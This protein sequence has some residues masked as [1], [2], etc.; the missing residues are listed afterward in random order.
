MKTLDLRKKKYEIIAYSK[1]SPNNVQVS[2]SYMYKDDA[3]RN[4]VL[5]LGEPVTITYEDALPDNVNVFAN[6]SR[7]PKGIAKALKVAFVNKTED[8]DYI[9]HDFSSYYCYSITQDK[10]MYSKSLDLFVVVD[11]TDFQTALDKVLYAQY[12][13]NDFKCVY[14]GGIYVLEGNLFDA[15]K[16]SVKDSAKFVDIKAVMKKY[17]ASLPSC[18]LEEMKSIYRMIA[19]SDEQTK[20]LGLKML[21]QYSPDDYPALM[22][23]IFRCGNYAISKLK[24]HS[25]YINFYSSYVTTLRKHYSRKMSFWTA[26]RSAAPGT[27]DQAIMSWIPQEKLWLT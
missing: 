13:T 9:V 24:S 14:N 1:Y 20:E 23:Y 5:I 4:N 2:C 16:A 7:I 25:S 3:N 27:D 22:S 26:E 17:G 10:I 8:A 15:Y 12:E 11:N 18:P 21:I 19:C 6:T